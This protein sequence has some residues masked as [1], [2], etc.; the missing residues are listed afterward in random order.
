MTFL[1]GSFGCLLLGELWQLA[2]ASTLDNSP[3]RH[4]LAKLIEKGY[5]K[6]AFAMA[7]SRL[8][9]KLDNF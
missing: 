4:V 2:A 6:N 9:N 5:L 3:E 7:T 1:F 8:L